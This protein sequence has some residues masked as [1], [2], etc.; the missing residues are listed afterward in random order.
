MQPLDGCSS[1]PWMD[2]DPRA[3]LLTLGLTLTRGRLSSNNQFLTTKG[4][5]LDLDICPMAPDFLLS[6]L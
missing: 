2:F 1:N 5:T 6:V 3:W 4:S